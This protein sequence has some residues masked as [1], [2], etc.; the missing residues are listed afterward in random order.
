MGF[1]ERR[2]S[3]SLSISVALS[4]EPSN[5]AFVLRTALAAVL[6]KSGPEPVGTG[7][8]ALIY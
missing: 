3:F 2:L 6:L 5:T 8:F 4:Y 1:I 7:P